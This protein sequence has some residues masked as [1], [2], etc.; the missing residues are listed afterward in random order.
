MNPFNIDMN[1]FT[2]KVLNRDL[3]RTNLFR[4][5]VN[6]QIIQKVLTDKNSKLFNGADAITFGTLGNAISTARQLVKKD[7]ADLGLMCKAVALPGTAIETE[8]NQTVKP[9]KTVPKYNT[10][11]PFTLT[12][13]ADS[14]QSNKIF[15]EDW[16]N[17]V[18]DKQTGLVGYYDDYV[19]GIYVYTYDRKGVPTSLTYFHE[20]Y[21]SNI[22]AVNLSWD[23][24]N[25][26]MVYDVEFTYRW[27]TTTD[28]NPASIYDTIA[29]N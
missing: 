7:F 2:G 26:V 4:V 28:A 5:Q 9:F 21:P 18:I 20:C 16:M 22:G 25:E 27:S 6:P 10:F 8:S 19:T 15:F 13:Y 12:F 14:D 29:K 11:A 1:F 3:A 17:F 24:N 23:N